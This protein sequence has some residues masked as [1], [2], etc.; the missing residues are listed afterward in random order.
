MRAGMENSLTFHHQQ[1][2]CLVVSAGFAAVG[3]VSYAEHA[4]RFGAFGGVAGAGFGMSGYWWWRLCGVGPPVVVTIV[5]RYRALLF[6][7]SQ[8]G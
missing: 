7:K 4:F 1:N 6:Y 5:T 8:R 2:F 3:V